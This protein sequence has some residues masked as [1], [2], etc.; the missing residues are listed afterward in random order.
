MILY[1]RGHEHDKLSSDD[2]KKG[3]F[4]ALEKLG[5]KKKILVIP[6]DFTR[7]HSRAGELTDYVWKYYN[8]SLT[9]ILPAIGTHFPMTE[10][11]IKLMF[12]DTPS[13]PETKKEINYVTS[14]AKKPHGPYLGDVFKDIDEKE[15]EY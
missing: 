1:K 3:L 7:Y 15:E 5:T 8:K 13:S 6:P 10:K 9:D 11:E 4:E 14:E 12:K 2:L